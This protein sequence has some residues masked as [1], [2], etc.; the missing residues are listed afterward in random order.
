LLNSLPC[1][2]ISH[3]GLKLTF[4]LHSSVCFNPLW[5]HLSFSNLDFW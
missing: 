5:G 3:P 4:L 2:W 1:C